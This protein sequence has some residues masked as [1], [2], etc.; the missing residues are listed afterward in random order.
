MEQHPVC[1]EVMRVVGSG[2]DGRTVEREL[3]KSPFGW[4]KDAI[5]GALISLH[6]LGHLTAR[7]SGAPVPPRGLDQAKVGRAEFRVETATIS[8]GDKIKLKALFKEAGVSVKGSEDI[9][10]KS[11]EFI[12]KLERLAEAAGGEAPLPKRPD[13]KHLAD[14]RGLAGNERLAKMLE[15]HDELKKQASAWASAAELSASRMPEWKRLERLLVHGIDCDELTETR[16]S[17]ESVRSGRLLLDTTDHAKPLV[18]KAAGVLRSAVNDAHKALV[19]VH[20]SEMQKLEATDAWK[21][22]T[23]DQRSSILAE[24]GIA[25][26]PSIQVGS[27][28]QLLATLDTTP[29]PSWRDKADALPKRFASAAMKAAK[30]LEP[31]TQYVRLSSSTL[32]TE[33]EV[34]AWVAEQE[35]K[36]LGKLAEGPIVIH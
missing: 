22:I 2:A 10:E 16:S 9:S 36:L 19:D 6:S 13:T 24:E 7:Y 35:A 4:P 12:E 5:D 14:L 15:L 27:D 25:D 21:K 23:A 11:S 34:K 18:K 29:L 32:T 17:A 3:S 26:T 30:L 28:D 8:P 20:D 1:K 31:K 33:P